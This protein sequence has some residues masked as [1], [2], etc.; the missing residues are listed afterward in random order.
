MKALIVIVA[1]FVVAAALRALDVFTGNKRINS[2]GAKSNKESAK[3]PTLNI[4]D[5]EELKEALK[6]YKGLED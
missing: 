5:P 6:Q 4:N 3:I 2:V 1:F